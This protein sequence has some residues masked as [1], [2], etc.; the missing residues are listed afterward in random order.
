MKERPI[1]FSGAMVRAIL[2][3]RKTQTR[4]VAKE[5]AG[6]DDLDLILRRF[7]HQNGCPYGQ[8]GDRLWVREAFSGPWCME[9]Q[10]GMAA[11]PPS[12]W[13][14]TSRIWYWADG[15]PTHGDWTRPRP[16]IHMPRW[17]SRITLEITGVRV[18]RLQD[19]SEADAVAEGCGQDGSVDGVYVANNPRGAFFHL[20]RQINGPGSWDANP[21]V[22]VVSFRRIAP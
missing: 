8:A 1:L 22:W 18:E 14:A 16:S 6:R 11:T 15:S 9:A 20:W 10:G 5:F 13:G 21:Y 12:K 3:G 4:R 2:D 17:A 7:P 19:I